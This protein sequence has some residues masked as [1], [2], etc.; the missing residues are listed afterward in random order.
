MSIRWL[1]AY[2]IL[3][4]YL[5]N[6]NLINKYENFEIDWKKCIKAGFLLKKNYKVYQNFHVFEQ[7]ICNN[8]LKL[9]SPS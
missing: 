8:L 6:E 7:L 4:I 9:E 5:I 3:F 2:I 1:I